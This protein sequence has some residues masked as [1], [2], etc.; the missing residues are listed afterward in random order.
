MGRT[1][2]LLP[3]SCLG[4]ALLAVLVAVFAVGSSSLLSWNRPGDL[5]FDR[6]IVQGLLLGAL[7]AAAVV[8]NM[9][10]AIYRATERKDWFWLFAS[11]LLWPLSFWYTLVET[12]DGR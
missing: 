10:I 7:P 9:L 6:G 8:A 3:K 11:L 5:I 12:D 4:V 2:N 1:R